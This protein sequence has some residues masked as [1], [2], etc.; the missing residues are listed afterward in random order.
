ML[1]LGSYEPRQTRRA[2]LEAVRVVLE[3]IVDRLHDGRVAPRHDPERH[4]QELPAAR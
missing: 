3:I 4:A 2:M 1:M